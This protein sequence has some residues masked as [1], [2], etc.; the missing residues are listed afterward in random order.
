I[1]SIAIIVLGIGIGMIRGYNYGI[2]FTGGTMMQIDIGKPVNETVLN[3]LQAVLSGDNIDADLVVAGKEGDQVIIKTIQALDT[4]AREKVLS[5][6]FAKFNLNDDSV[7]TIEQFGPSVGDMLKKNAVKAVIIASIGM[8]IYISIRFEWKFGLA[9]IIAVLHDVFILIAFYG[10]FHMTINNP[11]IAAVLTIVGY[12]IMDTIVI[13]DRIRENLDIMKRSKLE[14][15]IDHSINQT[16]GRSLM[17]SVATVIAIIPLCIMGGETIRNFTLPLI[18]GIVAGTGSSIYIA[19]PLY[20]QLCIAAG[21]SKYK[22]G[23]SKSKNKS[24][25]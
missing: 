20:Y 3:D 12:S 19:S 7:M 4:A 8:L 23:K 1:I 18:I 22:A 9:S 14:E 10:I 6:I 15:L 21:S 5:D 17:T 13:F 2:D 24:R 25:D 16:L 11:F